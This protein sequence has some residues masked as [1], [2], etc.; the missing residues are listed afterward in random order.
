MKVADFFCGAG[1]FSE[2][3]R[4]AGFDIIFAL[5]NWKPAIETHEFNHP[6][7]KTVQMNILDIKPEKIDEKVPDTEILIGSPPCV[8]FSGSNK[9]GKADKSLGLMLIEKYLQIVAHK[10]NKP[11]S[12]LKYWILENVPNVKRFIKE[13][14]TFEELGLI[15]GNKVALNVKKSETYNAADFGVPQ[16]RR[17]MFCGDFPE[18]RK[19]FNDENEW[20][21]LGDVLKTLNP[22]NLDKQII[23][24]NYGFFIQKENL[25]DHFYDTTVDDFEWKKAKRLKVDHGYMGK[26]SFPENE[27]KPSRTIMATMSSSTRESMIL[28]SD[29]KSYRRPTIREVSTLMSFPITYQFVGNSETTKYKLVGNAVCVRLIAALA[30]AIKEK[31]SLVTDEFVFPAFKRPPFVLDGLPRKKKTIKPRNIKSKFKMHVPGLKIR[32][33]RVDIDN[34]MSDFVK[35]N[36][37]WKSVLH[38]GSGKGA[39]SAE[40]DNLILNKAMMLVPGFSRFEEDVIKEFD[41]NLPGPKEFQLSYCRLVNDNVIGPEKVLETIKKLVEKH[42]QG[43]ELKDV[44]NLGIGIERDTIPLNVLAALYACN[45]AMRTVMSRC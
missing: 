31:E 30:K 42:F 41:G 39:R 3:F 33:F 29:D 10:K 27:N 26:M 12:I 34:H 4:Q 24:I 35:G 2:G 38:Y 1:G 45:V 22:K 8:A 15:G 17:R 28:N 7:A 9:A 43:K 44:K 23:D 20:V 13:K 5:D 14:Y 19:V 25:T 36:Y 21:K 11:G 32:S 16:T 6:E 37:A 40:V 18:P